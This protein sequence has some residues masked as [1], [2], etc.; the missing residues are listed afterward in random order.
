MTAS[1]SPGSS[2]GPVLNSNGELIGISV[3]QLT[4]GQNLNFAIPKSYLQ[5]LLDFKKDTPISLSS[6]ISYSASIIGKPIRIGTI[7]VAQNDFPNSLNWGDAIK[8]C[9]DLGSG[10]RLPTKYELNLMFLNKD[11]VGGFITSNDSYSNGYWSSTEF[12]NDYMWSQLFGTGYPFICL[13][14]GTLYVRAVRSL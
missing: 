3:S 5:I 2:G 6:L 8:A 10:W 9:A 11:K 4:E 14:D 13:K 12:K 7:E 1:I